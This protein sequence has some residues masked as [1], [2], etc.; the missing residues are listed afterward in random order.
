MLTH[1]PENRT[2]ISVA[3]DWFFPVL[4]NKYYTYRNQSYIISDI[5]VPVGEI[6]PHRVTFLTRRLWSVSMCIVL[7]VR[8]SNV[9]FPLAAACAAA[10]VFPSCRAPMVPQTPQLVVR[11][12]CRN[13]GSSHCSCRSCALGVRGTACESDGNGCEWIVKRIY[14]KNLS[15]GF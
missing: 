11:V 2:T 14:L 15:K 10:F 7:S 9:L 13:L 6:H 3:A 4:A 12:N 5:T 8:V 1:S